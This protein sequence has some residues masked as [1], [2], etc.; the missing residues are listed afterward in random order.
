MPN[1][2]SLHVDQVVAG[3]LTEANPVLCG[4]LTQRGFRQ[5]QQRTNQLQPRIAGRRVSPFHSSQSFTATAPKQAKK[6]QLE[7]IVGMMCQRDGGDLQA[8]CCSSQE[9][10]TE[11]SRGHFNRN[12]SCL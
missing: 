8:A 3:I 12:T 11:L 2:V 7:L 9:I 10:M 6:E 5:S 4:K 1:A